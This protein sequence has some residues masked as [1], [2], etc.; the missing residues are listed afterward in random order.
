MVFQIKLVVCRVRDEMIPLLTTCCCGF[1]RLR[2]AAMLVAALLAVR[3]LV[4][5]SYT[6]PLPVLSNSGGL[7]STVGIATRYSLHAPSFE[8]L[9]KRVLLCRPDRLLSPPSLLYVQ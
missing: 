3:R 1:V 2:T 8:S 5:N 9:W 7:D 6:S 4:S